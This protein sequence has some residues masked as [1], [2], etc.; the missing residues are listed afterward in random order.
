MDGLHYQ[1]IIRGDA[2]LARVGIS[3]E[4]DALCRQLEVTA[5]VYDDRGLAAELWDA[6]ESAAGDFN[7]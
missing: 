4:Q 1:D 6:S 7:M 5:G 3:A 2:G